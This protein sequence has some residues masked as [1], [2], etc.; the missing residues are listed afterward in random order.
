MVAAGARVTFVVDVPEGDPVLRW[1]DGAIGDP[2]PRTITVTADGSHTEFR[3]SQPA[4]S[5]KGQ[6]LSLEPWAGTRITIE[7]ATMALPDRGPAT[8]EPADR[9]VGVFGSP[10]VS[11]PPT[12]QPAPDILVYLVDALR[13]DRIGAWGHG[14]ARTPNLDRLARD[15]ATFSRVISPSCWTK[16]AVVTL[17]TGIH[18][19]THGVGTNSGLDL[20]PAGVPV[21]QHRFATAGWRTGSF[22]ANPLASNLSNL[23]RGFDAAYLPRFWEGNIG[24]FLHPTAGQLHDSLLDWIAEAPDRPFFAYVHTLEVHQNA[25]PSNAGDGTQ[26][27]QAYDRAVS[28]ADTLLGSLLEQL[29]DQG[30]LDNLVIVFVSDHGES[31]G[32]HGILGHGQSLY[33]TEIHIPLILWSPTHIPAGRHDAPVGLA[34]IGPTLLELSGLAP[35]AGAQGSSLVPELRG[36]VNAMHQVVASSHQGFT[37]FPGIPEQH[38]LIDSGGRKIMQIQGLGEFS[39]D[40]GRDA[41]EQAPTPVV[42]DDVRAELEAWLAGQRASRKQF[43]LEYGTAAPEPVIDAADLESLRSLGYIP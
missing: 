1:Y 2:G 38:S 12:S 30:R 40:L 7:L 37:F 32:E 13:A 19:T 11:S 28:H 33:Q 29:E 16:P 42:E 24:A 9:G 25:M 22:T 20:L 39:F 41:G 23:D 10:E 31:L 6:M 26:N 14:A 8:Q 18:P 43:E 34:D 3:E 4:G 35:L 17:M 27:P 5:W 15:G 21:L 36:K